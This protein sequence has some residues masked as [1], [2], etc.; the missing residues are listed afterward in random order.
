ARVVPLLVLDDAILRGLE[1]A[2]RVSFLLDALDDLRGS[3]RERGA[4]LVL[5]RGDPVAEALRIVRSVGAQRLFV[6]GDAS[7]HAQARERRLERDCTAEHV[8][9]R[10]VNT[11]AI[12]PP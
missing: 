11:L 6:G 12:V 1:S 4:D 8:D 9:L 2:N 7:A 3:L 10:V 5:Q